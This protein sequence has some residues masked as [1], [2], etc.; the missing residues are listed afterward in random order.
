[1]D[2][3]YKFPDELENNPSEVEASITDEGDVDIEIVDDTPEQD[4]NRK[5]LKR[6]V[7]DPSDDELK[8]YGAGVSKRIKELT[9]ARHDE[10]RAKE[11]LAREKEEL[12]RVA[13]H[14]YNENQRLRTT[15]NHGEQVLAGSFKSAASAE[16]EMAKKQ[17]KEAH[18][19]FDAD[20]IV[21]AQQALTNAQIKL[22]NAERFQPSALQTQQP[23]VQPQQEAPQPVRPD[24]KTLRWQARNQWFGNNDEMTAVAYAVHRELVNSGVDPREDEYFEQ[25]DARVKKRFPEFFGGEERRKST[26][27]VAP[28]TRSKGAIKVRLTPTALSLAKKYGLTPQQYAAEVAKLENQNG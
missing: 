6:D 11:S 4:R 2:D 17:F 7:D 12:E 21:E 28:V 27:V 22:Q 26:S 1:M 13:Q 14:L 3:E 23:M 24:D 25:L 16:L 18:E 10:R 19:A 5:P 15:V 9:H 20:A 8:Q